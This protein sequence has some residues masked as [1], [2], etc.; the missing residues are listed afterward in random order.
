MVVAISLFLAFLLTNKFTLELDF[1]KIFKPIPS[2]SPQPQTGGMSVRLRGVDGDFADVG[3]KFPQ[4]KTS[5]EGLKIE[6]KNINE[7]KQSLNNLEI[8]QWEFLTNLPKSI[9]RFDITLDNSTSSPNN[10]KSGSYYLVNQVSGSQ[11]KIFTGQKDTIIQSVR[12]ENLPE[13]LSKTKIE[14]LNDGGIYHKFY[15]K[16][17]NFISQ[18]TGSLIIKPT[19]FLQFLI[20]FASLVFVTTTLVLLKQ[21]IMSARD[22]NEVINYFKKN[23]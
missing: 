2:S 1:S 8:D 5:L 22:V 14:L 15:D 17:G 3:F 7:I 23:L 9:F 12:L 11:L 16:E 4:E 6:E 13:E 10:G 18:S 21:I 19:I 20:I